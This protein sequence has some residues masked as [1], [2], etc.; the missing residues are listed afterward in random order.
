MSMQPTYKVLSNYDHLIGRATGIN[1]DAYPRT[2]VE[3]G[4]L[5]KRLAIDNSPAMR[6]LA[7]HLKGNTPRQTLYNVWHFAK[8]NL[9][10]KRDDR[11]ADGSYLE[12]PRTPQR[13]WRDRMTGVDCEDYSAFIGSILHALNVPTDLDIVEQ[14]GPGSGFGHIYPTS[15]NVSLDIL[16]PFGVPAE[17]ITKRMKVTVLSG[18][19]TGVTDKVYEQKLMWLKLADPFTRKALVEVLPYV[20]SFTSSGIPIY[21]PGAP[22]SQIEELFAQHTA[23]FK[24]GDLGAIGA[25]KRKKKNPEQPQRG[26][27][28]AALRIVPAMILGRGAFIKLV[29]LNAFKLASKLRLMYLSE[30]KAKQA[31]LNIPE[32]KKLAD[33]K[34]RVERTWFNFGGDVDSLKKAIAKGASV[35]V[36]RLAEPITTGAIIAT[37]TPVLVGITAAIAGVDFKKMTDGTQEAQ[38]ADTASNLSIV[39]KAAVQKIL[40]RKKNGDANADKDMEL[41]QA[42][43]D[44]AAPTG[45]DDKTTRETPTDDK[46]PIWP[47]I[48]GG[49][50]VLGLGGAFVWSTMSSN[51]SKPKKG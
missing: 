28:N 18:V 42:A 5:I 23:N 45:T 12:Q 41:L 25:F 8:T 6:P 17:N 1:Y 30:D 11:R 40:D 50:V 14:A 35:D 33:R 4:D 19:T 2:I 46:K 43:T 10:Y 39:A 32:W 48:A 9:K 36:K 27:G 38:V 37:A 7:N 49:V 22:L 16:T 31:K 29:Q 51:S 26:I 34:S 13:T 20:E 3:L 21:K 44:A 47:W 24:D 15:N